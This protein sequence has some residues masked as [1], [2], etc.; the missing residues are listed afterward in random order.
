MRLKSERYK[1]HTIRFEKKN[2]VV[3]ASITGRLPSQVTAQRT[4]EKALSIAKKA[5]DQR[6]A[7]EKRYSVNTDKAAMRSYR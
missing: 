2:D 6:V 4:K 1:G 7:R 3:Y 5:V